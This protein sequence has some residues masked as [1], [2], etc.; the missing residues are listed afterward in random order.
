MKLIDPDLIEQLYQ[1]AAISPRLRAHYCLH[2]DHSEK[3]QRILIALAKGSYVEPHYHELPHQWEMFAL[4]KGALKVTRY[5]R[6]GAVEDEAILADAED[7]PQIIQFSPLEIHSVE[8]ISEFA[9]MLEV[10]EGPFD[11]SRA[12]V[13]PRFA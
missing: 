4:L 10:K 2:A 6:C 5:S 1:D 12:K 13:F 7:C 9:L 8:C 11:A 3:V